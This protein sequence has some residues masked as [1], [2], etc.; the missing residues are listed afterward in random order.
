MGGGARGGGGGGGLYGTVN[1]RKKLRITDHRYKNF[2][3]PNHDNKQVSYSFFITCS[4][5]RKS[6]WRKKNREKQSRGST[7]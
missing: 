2:V 4:Y 6:V 3:F 5:T 1:E 7:L